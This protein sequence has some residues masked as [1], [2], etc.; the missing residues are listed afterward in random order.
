MA[1]PDNAASTRMRGRVRLHFLDG[2]RGLSA[3]YVL[4]FHAHWQA[5]W[6]FQPAPLSGLTAA[7]SSLLD[8]GHA[9]VA[10]F[11]VLSGYCLMLPVARSGGLSIPG[12][13]GAYLLRRARRIMPPYYAAIGVS[14]LLIACLPALSHPGGERWA[15]ALPGPGAHPFTPEPHALFFH[16]LREY[17]RSSDVE[18]GS[19]MVDLFFVPGGALAALAGAGNV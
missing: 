2:M 1:Q 18:R 4:L 8:Y 5:D 15:V 7:I 3:F 10:V 17:H 16:P 9:A 6:Y 12:G 11:I 19:G 13:V 14:L